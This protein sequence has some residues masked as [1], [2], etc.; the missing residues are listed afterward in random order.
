MRGA[1]QGEH[2][3]VA[4]AVDLLPALKSHDGIP[5]LIAEDAVDPAT[6]EVGRFSWCCDP[7]GEMAN[8]TTFPLQINR[9][10]V[11]VPSG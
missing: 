11:S 2:T 7:K 6:L 4:I 8:S 10:R 5:R 9:G 1:P 3:D